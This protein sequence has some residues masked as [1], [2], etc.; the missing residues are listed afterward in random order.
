MFIWGMNLRSNPTLGKV[1]DVQTVEYIAHISCT[2]DLLR[3]DR[4]KIGSQVI[5]HV[6]RG[7]SVRLKVWGLRSPI[8]RRRFGGTAC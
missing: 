6:E 4:R 8:V 3:F 7:E 1:E 2:A 5:D